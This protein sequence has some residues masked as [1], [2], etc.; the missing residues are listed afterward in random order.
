MKSW[1][2][3]MTELSGLAKRQANREAVAEQKPLRQ[4]MADEL[5]T[6]TKVY[7]TV[8]WDAS[9]RLGTD[10]PL[11]FTTMGDLWFDLDFIG[12]GLVLRDGD[13]SEVD[14]I[15][16]GD[17]RDFSGWTMPIGVRNTEVCS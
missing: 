4:H 12:E 17:V 15:P 11:V 5:A 8:T 7:G 16:W 13:G 1:G 3:W 2:E 6:A 9:D 10:I 14:W